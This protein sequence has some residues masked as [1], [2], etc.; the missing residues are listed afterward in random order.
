M[1]FINLYGTNSIIIFV[2]FLILII[3][4]GIGKFFLRNTKINLWLTP[5]VGL[6]GFIFGIIIGAIANYPKTIKDSD[7]WYTS[8]FEFVE[9][10]GFLHISITAIIC[11][12]TSALSISNFFYTLII[13][14][15]KN[16]LSV[17]GFTLLFGIIFILITYASSNLLRLLN[18]NAYDSEFVIGNN[19]S[20]IGENLGG[21]SIWTDIVTFFPNL[22]RNPVFSISYIIFLLLASMIGVIFGFFF[23]TKYPLRIINNSNN[24]MYKISG[25]S[26]L[27]GSFSFLI[28][29]AMSSPIGFFWNNLCFI[30]INLIP[31]LI[32]LFFNWHL[33]LKKKTFNSKIFYTKLKQLKIIKSC[34]FASISSTMI[35]MFSN[36]YTFIGIPTYDSILP[37]VTLII[38]S[39][40]NIF[41]FSNKP[42]INQSQLIKFSTSIGTAEVISGLRTGIFIPG[43]SLLSLVSK[44]I[45]EKSSKLQKY[46]LWI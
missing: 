12:F 28:L 35:L 45:Y 43:I 17:T 29:F 32:L 36:Q 37:Q 7:L 31:F 4:I 16:S 20:K 33:K 21:F 14:R 39:F 42:A 1:N 41:I 3:L 38:I 46:F 30:T 19:F 2:I 25:I 23:Q 13:K 22:F 24:L 27:F 11:I 15:S 18:I 9:S 40:V 10:I 5:I 8:S 34:C 6:V 44:K 26:A